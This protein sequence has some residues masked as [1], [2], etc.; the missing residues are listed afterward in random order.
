MTKK[1]E[2]VKARFQEAI[3]AYKKLR[4]FDYVAPLEEFLNKPPSEPER[5][6]IQKSFL[7]GLKTRFSPESDNSLKLAFKAAHLDPQDPLDR[8]I[9]LRFFAAA[10][11]PSK[12]ETRGAKTKWTPERWNRLLSDYDQVKRNNPNL[13]DVEICKQIVNRFPSRYPEPPSSARGPAK[14]PGATVRRNLALARDPTKNTRLAELAQIF[15]D[16]MRT[17]IHKLHPNFD[18]PIKKLN[19]RSEFLAIEW[20]SKGVET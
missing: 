9:L 17:E 11:F 4:T 12:K 5:D 7:K 18:L 20:L 13:N 1:T 19:K 3:E 8:E 10:H 14:D 15:A 6:R 16:A 2:T